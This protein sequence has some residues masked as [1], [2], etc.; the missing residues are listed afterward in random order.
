MFFILIC[1]ALYQG[2]DIFLLDDPLSAVDVKVGKH[3]F[4]RYGD[5]LIHDKHKKKMQMDRVYCTVFRNLYVKA[6]G[7]HMVSQSQ[8]EKV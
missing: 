1:R 7:Y 2:G 5:S 6:Y 8:D 3:I 4:E